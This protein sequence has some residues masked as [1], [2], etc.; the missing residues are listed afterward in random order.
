MHHILTLSL[1]RTTIYTQYMGRTEETTLTSYQHVRCSPDL[2]STTT[3]APTTT[4]TMP[5]T[6]SSKKTV[7]SD[8]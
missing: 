1:H 3:K 4:V 7:S 6:T 5:T 8:T 2:V